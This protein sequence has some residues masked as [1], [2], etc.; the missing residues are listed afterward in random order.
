MYYAYFIYLLIF[1]YSITRDNASANNTL[2]K[3]VKKH[4]ELSGSSFYGDVACL[5]HILN[6]VV[7]DIL[8]IIIKDKYYSL[9]NNT[10]SVENN[11]D[12]NTIGKLL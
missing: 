11:K 2:I 7:Q 3:K 9:D 10:Y 4:Y 8:K 5:A 1:L 6:L 12:T